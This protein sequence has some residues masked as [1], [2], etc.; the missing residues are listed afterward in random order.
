MKKK[1]LVIL[2]HPYEKSLCNAVAE[3]Y[4]EGAKE[5]GADVK[6]LKIGNLKFNPNLEKGYHKIQKLEPDL[7]NA[8]KMIK[9][10]DHL[11]WVYPN[12]WSTMPALMKGFIDRIFLPG[13]GFQFKKNSPMWD[14]LFTGKTAH[15]I[16]T[17]NSP[18]IV[19]T[20]MFGKPGVNQMKKGILGFCGVKPV[21]ATILSPAEMAS[22]QKISQWLN[23]IKE[24][25]RK[26]L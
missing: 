20:L 24:K 15:L 2:G 17:M 11:V 7:K 14:K 22:K 8:Q 1:I 19:Y 9:W 3:S 10:A 25:G 26:L 18:K 6:V 16:I 5:A 12:W 13:F 23:K 4:A 21:R